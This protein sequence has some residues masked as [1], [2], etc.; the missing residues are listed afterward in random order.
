MCK[1]SE[2]KFV[3][4]SQY[5]LITQCSL[6]YISINGHKVISLYQVQTLS[7]H[8]YIYS[9]E[10]LQNLTYKCNIYAFDTEAGIYFWCN[11]NIW[12]MLDTV[13]SKHFNDFQLMGIKSS[14]Y[15]RHTS[16]SFYLNS[17]W[18]NWSGIGFNQDHQQS[19][20]FTPFYF[21]RFNF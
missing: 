14:A 20:P 15:A 11:Y 17:T 12:Q 16:H 5:K 2:T 9:L 7:L 18:E 3:I 10:L 8:I 19:H 4:C 13:N 21:T 6:K 1:D